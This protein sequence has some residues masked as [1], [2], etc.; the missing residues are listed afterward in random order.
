MKT[1]YIVGNG[2]DLYHGLKTSYKDFFEFVLIRSKIGCSEAAL[3][4][5]LKNTGADRRYDAYYVRW[6]KI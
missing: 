5:Y 4:K 6:K 3:R 2:F 1:L